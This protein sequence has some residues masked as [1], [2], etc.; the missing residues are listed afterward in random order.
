MGRT[1][2]WP[3]HKAEIGVHEPQRP[4]PRHWA[5]DSRQ[6]YPKALSFQK[7]VRVLAEANG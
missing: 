6:S 7:A 5:Y 1:H 4:V 2:I 3:V